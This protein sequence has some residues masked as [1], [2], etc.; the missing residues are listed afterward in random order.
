M[1]IFTK[2]YWVEKKGLTEEEA[3]LKIKEIQSNNA[4]KRSK[5]SYKNM[6]MP[7][8]EEY[9]V[10]EGF[11]KIEAKEKSNENRN[12]LSINSLSK[13]K[14]EEIL[15]NRKNTYYNKSLEERE[16][17]NKSRGRTKEEL[18]EKYGETYVEELSIK[19]GS[20]RKN[21]F[22]RRYSKIS[23]IFFDE[24]NENVDKELLYAEKE[25]WVRYNS[26]KGFYVDCLYKNKIIEFN[27][28]FYHAN[29]K[30][31]ES[32]SIIKMSAKKIQTAK[33]IWKKDEFRIKKLSDLGYDIL[34]IWETEI[35][36]NKKEI[37][38]KCIKF[39]NNG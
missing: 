28:D 18:I 32:T 6:L 10:K 27:G 39:L 29:P 25:K 2:K 38:N 1:S 19:R 11:S 22:F 15:K 16:K 7:W 31:Y 36:E 4:K 30:L 9:W 37:L 8:Q 14:K 34:I 17:I 23:K 5:E 33:E 24:L 21:S 13:T 3:I 20:G 26:N 35:R 12:K